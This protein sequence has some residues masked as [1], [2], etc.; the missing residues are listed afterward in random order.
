MKSFDDS[1]KFLV[2]QAPADFIAFALGGATVRVVSPLSAALPSR[3][4][5]IDEAFLAEI[6]GTQLVAHLEYVRRHQTEEELGVDVVEA[7]VR[8]FRRERVPV[9]SLVFDLYG[10]HKGELLR[11]REL[12]FGVGSKSSYRQINLRGQPVEDLLR[13]GPAALWP[14]AP[15]FLGGNTAEGVQHAA[16]AILGRGLSSATEADHLSVLYF[17]AE[18]EGLPLQLLKRYI[19]RSKMIE[20]QLYKEIFKEGEDQGEL[21]GQART[22]LRVLLRRFDYLD[23]DLSR[24]IL[25]ETRQDLLELWLDDALAIPSA[26]KLPPLVE[27]ILRTALPQAR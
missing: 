10:R 18:H 3:S 17:I 27:R 20:S 21:K 14:L 26:E 4:R 15:L 24:R 25:A 12:T 2:Q 1:L 9:Q 19:P 22:L 13:S 8:L 11:D 7:Q 23:E 6:N 16:A 5:T